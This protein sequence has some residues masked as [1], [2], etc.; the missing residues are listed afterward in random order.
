LRVRRGR[1]GKKKRGGGKRKRERK[2]EKR[3][4]EGGVSQHDRG[5]GKTLL[6][7]VS[8]SH[9]YRAYSSPRPKMEL[10]DAFLSILWW[11]VQMGLVVDVSGESSQIAAPFSK[12]FE[13]L[14]KSR[15]E[16]GDLSVEISPLGHLPT[17][18]RPYFEAKRHRELPPA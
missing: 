13:S 4:G 2:G 17:Q 5:G 15:D 9:R 14:L 11:Y 7:R 18:G 10:T 3:K 16:V 12:I 6:C 1:G 8:R